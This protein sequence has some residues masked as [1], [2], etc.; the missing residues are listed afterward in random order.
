MPLYHP[1]LGATHTGWVNTP[2]ENLE[3]RRNAFGFEHACFASAERSTA[4][5]LADTPQHQSTD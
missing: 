2:R 4:P 5:R 1:K 3:W